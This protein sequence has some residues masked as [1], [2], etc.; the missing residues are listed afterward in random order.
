MTLFAGHEV[1]DPGRLIRLMRELL[2]ARAVHDT[3]RNARDPGDVF[4]ILCPGARHQLSGV[5][6]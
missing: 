1:V 3:M 4:V 2:L 5:A 6:R